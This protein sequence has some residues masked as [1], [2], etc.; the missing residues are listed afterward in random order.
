MER[1]Q[2]VRPPLLVS[3]C[4]VGLDTRL[5][6]HCRSFPTVA[7]LARHYTLIPVCPEQLGGLSTPRPP[8]EIIG[9]SGDEVLRGNARVCTEEGRDVTA[10]YIKGAEQALR[11]ARLNGV[12]MAVLKARSPS[13]GVDVTY[14]GTF[15]HT[16][17]SGS[18][19]AAARLQQDGFLLYTEENCAQLL[20]QA[21]VSGGPDGPGE[22]TTADGRGF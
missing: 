2:G 12:R 8:A 5:D 11:A 14:D 18:G 15:S 3:A 17:R 4:L 10:A 16:L 6:G 21:E 22:V 9:G 19:V 1:A 20:H 13:C 7:T